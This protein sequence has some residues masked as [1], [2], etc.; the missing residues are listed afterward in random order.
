MGSFDVSELASALASGMTDTNDTKPLIIYLV[1]EDWAFCSHRLPTAHGAVAAGLRVGVAARA[2]KHAEKIRQMGFK[3][4]PLAWQRRS[5][6]PLL[7]LRDLWQIT[8]LYRHERPQITHHVALK[9]VMLG[10]IA[11]WLARVPHQVA[12]INGVGFAF[13]DPG[14]LARLL[15]L[16]FVPL[17]RFVLRRPNVSVW[18]QN[19]DDR[20]LLLR[21]GVVRL[22][23]TVLIRGS[24]VDTEK[25]QP[26]PEPAGAITCAYAGRMLH[27]K[28]ID[29]LVE[30]VQNCRR[31]GIDLH[32]LLAGSTDDNPT[33]FSV[34]QLADWNLLDGVNFL[35]HIA[36]I[37]QL[38][39]QAHIAVLPCRV[40]EGLPKTL[41]DA[42]ACARPIVASDVEGVREIARDG[43]NALLV[44]ASDL[45]ALTAALAKLATDANLRQQLGAAGRTL[46]DTQG[47]S[48][49]AVQE[50]AQKFYRQFI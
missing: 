19:D 11:A 39:A 35:G 37:N 14:L 17:L 13:S 32:L 24:G 49:K 22:D 8:S 47:M 4:F 50:Q 20:N 28:G 30:A 10:G 29:L 6:N 26:L 5:L 40:R 43:V 38:W 16:I 25:L 23:Q 12:A 18:F 31:Q 34:D 21:L 2:D 9:A 45:A 36:D 3:F 33:S 1:T 48:A 41:L 46:L 27:S 7:A 42:T 15:R 44:P